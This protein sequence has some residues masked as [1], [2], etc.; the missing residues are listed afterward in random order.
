M[1]KESKFIPIIMTV[2]GI[3]LT[4]GQCDTIRVALMA[5]SI[6]LDANGLGDNEGSKE[7][8][9]RYKA[10]IRAITDIL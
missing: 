1:T 4:Q 2:N 3:T 10:A 9:K 7:M 6:D 5:F 8:V